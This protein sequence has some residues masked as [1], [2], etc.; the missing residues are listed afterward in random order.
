M[1]GST[2]LP[3]DIG[4]PQS[5]H[6]IRGLW[7]LWPWSAAAPS[8]G[9]NR[10]ARRGASSRTSPSPC[11]SCSPEDSSARGPHSTPP[12]GWKKNR[13][14][15][16]LT[17]RSKHF[18]LIHALVTKMSFYSFKKMINGHLRLSICQSDLILWNCWWTDL[19]QGTAAPLSAA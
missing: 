16:D 18:W 19:N 6:R 2:C 17:R 8:E 7:R 11:Y 15:A 4:L 12:E 5:R 1:L 3:R 9:R 10:R 14:E 13:T